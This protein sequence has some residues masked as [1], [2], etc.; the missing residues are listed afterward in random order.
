MHENGSEK[1]PHFIVTPDMR[2]AVRKAAGLGLP[3]KQIA[4]LIVNPASMKAISVSILEKRFANELEDGV[5][6]A[7]REVSAK[8]YALCLQGNINAIR[9]WET[10][11][12]GRYEKKDFRGWR[13]GVNGT[14]APEHLSQLTREQILALE[15]V[16]KTM[17]NGAPPQKGGKPRLVADNPA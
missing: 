5:A 4:R 16:L 8:L 13:E 9:W 17:G 12:M 11:R 10:T 1:H 2:E 7:N 3:N 6:H 15:S 14:L